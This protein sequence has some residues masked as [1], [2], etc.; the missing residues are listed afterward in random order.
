MKKL[1]MIYLVLLSPLSQGQGSDEAAVVMVLDQYHQAAATADWTVYFDLMSE[2]AVFLGTDVGERWPK[3]QFREYAGTRSGWMY[4]PG[5]RNINFT[6]DGNTAWFDEIL[7]SA[8]YGTSR[9]TGVLIRTEGGW[10]ISQYHLTFPIPNDL[11]RE[12]TDRIKTY[13]NR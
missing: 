13:E 9:G 6:P 1:M 3:A 4:T 10:K 8:S 12:I 11:A 5:E 7:K 2:D